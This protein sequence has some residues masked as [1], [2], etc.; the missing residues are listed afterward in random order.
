MVEGLGQAIGCLFWVAALALIISLGAG[1]YVAYDFFS[2]EKIES[3]NKIE[4]E[5][6]LTTDGKKIDTIYVYKSKK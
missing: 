5:I 4:P 6:K 1:S 2:T 3:P